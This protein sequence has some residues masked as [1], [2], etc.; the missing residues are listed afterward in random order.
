MLAQSAPGQFLPSE[1]DLAEQ[2]G[3]SRATLR[4]AMRLYEARGL[5]VRRRGIGTYVVRPPQVIESGL[6]VLSSIENLAAQ[7]GVA[8]EAREVWLDERPAQ[9]EEA[10]LLRIAAGEP[11]VELSRLI[12]AD[13][14][15]VAY[16]VD[17]LPREYLDPE[18]IDDDFTG[19]VLS[20]LL[21]RGDLELDRSRA[22]ITA[23]P[24]EAEVAAGLGI[25][26]GDVVLYLEAILL[27][28]AGEVVDH[29]RSYFLPGTFRLHAV[30]HVRS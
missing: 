12:V 14:R 6:E 10:G 16:F 3:V 15:P 23:L 5:V 24:V 13:G 22:E 26:P 18:Q 17:C 8:L 28:V 4:E 1:P 9:P 25:H 19:S 30:R 7:V 27:T 11:I 2:F 21:K 29:S 20:L